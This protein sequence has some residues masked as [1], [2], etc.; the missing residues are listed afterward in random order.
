MAA[1]Q[2]GTWEAAVSWLITTPEQ[3]K[4]VLDCYYDQPLQAAAERYWLSDEWQ[5]IRS[6]LPSQPGKALDIGAGHGISSYALAKEGWHVSALEPDPSDLV[7]VGAIQRLAREAQLP[8]TVTQEFGEQLPF[9]EAYF[10]VVFARQVLHHAQDLGQLCREI[11]RV[12][13]PGGTLVA[14]KDHVI[15]S[16]KDLGRFLERHPLHNF[17]GGENAFLLKEYTVAIQSAGLRLDQL[18]RP[19]DTVINYAPYSKDELR[20]GFF[21]RLARIPL[22]NVPAKLLTS[23]LFFDSFLKVMSYLDQRPGRVYSFVAQKPLKPVSRQS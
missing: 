15:S 13:K 10:D 21:E 1:Q 9:A 5:A 8:I 16:Q 2:F 4:V 19:F 3:Q 23:D 12:L 7:G 22:M 11:A 14:V 18:L 6:F 20:A 17:Y